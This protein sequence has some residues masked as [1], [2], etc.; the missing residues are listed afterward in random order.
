MCLPFRHLASRYTKHYRYLVL[1]YDCLQT[2]VNNSGYMVK[3]LHHCE[4]IQHW[5][6]S[7]FLNV[8]SNMRILKCLKSFIVFGTLP[9][10]TD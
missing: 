1:K 3:Q 6:Y 8:Q 9:E 7:I 10:K 5:I 2:L 4:N